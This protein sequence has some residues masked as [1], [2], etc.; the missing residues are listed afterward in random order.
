M[1]RS[2]PMASEVIGFAFADSIAFL[3]ASDW[4]LRVG[5]LRLVP[6]AP[7]LRTAGA[8]PARESHHALCLGLRGGPARGGHRCTEP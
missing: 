2:D 4:D 1:S 8:E 5:T 3:N 6:V 7:L